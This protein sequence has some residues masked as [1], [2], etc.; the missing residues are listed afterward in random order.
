M[1]ECSCSSYTNPHC[2]LHG[3][4][5]KSAPSTGDSRQWYIIIGR[6]EDKE[7][8]TAILYCEDAIEAQEWF[9]RELREA[10][11]DDDALSEL[12]I[13]GL[14]ACGQT[15]PL[16]VGNGPDGRP[17]EAPVTRTGSRYI[18]AQ[19]Y[20]HRDRLRDRWS[21]HDTLKDAK[22]RYE[23]VVADPKTHTASL[24]LIIEDTD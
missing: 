19:T 15:K 1:F 11:D 5:T 7:N 20:G 6:L 10:A 2:P 4:H 12:Y 24:A 16:D 14:F 8:E 13:E 22:T 23:L 21:R 17:E 9:G 3:E 18:V